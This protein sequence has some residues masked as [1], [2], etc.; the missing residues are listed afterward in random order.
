MNP[1]LFLHL[2]S[3]ESRK[4]LSYR[5]DFWLTM[6]VSLVVQVVVVWTL[7]TAVFTESG[8]E[9]VG[10]WDLQGIFAYGIF[11]FL[12]GRIIRGGDLQMAVAS[13]IYDGSLSRYLIYPCNYCWT[14]YAQQLGNIF[15]DILQSLLMALVILP[16]LGTSSTVD[17]NM[18]GI[19]MTV[20][21]LFCAHLLFFI[22]GLIPQMVAFW[23]DNVWSLSVMI[24]MVTMLLGG[25]SIPLSLFPESL[26]NVLAWLPFRYLFEF[27]TL[28][29]LGRIGF[30]EW[31]LGL[32][33]CLVWCGVF[34]IILLPVWRRGTLRYTGVGI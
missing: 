27:P 2:M 4:L 24:R 17:L 3:I 34:L 9:I 7:W 1:A 32:L 20:P 29:L 15:P 33:S 14:K 6:I 12:L 8:K 11:A 21:T 30:E 19:L 26:Q 13:E 28:V 5:V 23:A 22:M 16:F 10:G 25:A 18:T 31:A